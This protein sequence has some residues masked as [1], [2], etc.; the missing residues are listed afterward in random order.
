MKKKLQEKQW[1]MAH[2]CGSD[3]GVFSLG[4]I[5]KSPENARIVHSQAPD[6]INKRNLEAAIKTL[7]SGKAL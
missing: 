2:E 3:E 4:N 6:E 1:R 5:K 7:E